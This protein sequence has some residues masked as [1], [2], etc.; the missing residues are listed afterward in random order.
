MMSRCRAQHGWG[1]GVDVAAFGLPSYIIQSRAKSGECWCV[2]T[3]RV[4]GLF[5]VGDVLDGQTGHG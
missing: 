3:V 2:W 1:E 4:C 5:C